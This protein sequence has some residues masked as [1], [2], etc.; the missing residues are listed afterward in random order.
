MESPLQLLAQLARTLDRCRIE[1]VVVGSW[2]SSTRGMYRTTNDIDILAEINPSQV[3]P[4]VTRLEKDFYID[5]QAVQRAISRHGSFNILHFES[6]FKFDIFVARDDEFVRQQLARRTL[7]KTGP[8]S[9]EYVYV[10]SAEDTI[11]AKLEWFNRGGRVSTV[12]WKDVAGLIG[13]Q[14]PRLD[15]VYLR[16]WAHH[17]GVGELLEE[18]L[19]E[20]P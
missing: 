6:V 13:T 2:A 19:D 20:A 18:A 9:N 11:L 16:D 4:L 7:E 5:E 12:Q 8:D 10:A 15:L 14:G 1:Y 17:L 3:K